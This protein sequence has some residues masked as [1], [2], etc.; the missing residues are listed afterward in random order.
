M[1]IGEWTLPL[2]IVLAGIAQIVSITRAFG[3][4]KT[5]VAVLRAQ[6]SD[7]LKEHDKK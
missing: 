7:H 2:T 6:F 1:N 3:E 4:L 5:Q